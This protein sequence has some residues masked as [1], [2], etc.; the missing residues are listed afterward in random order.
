MLLIEH[1]KERQD[2]TEKI[3]TKNRREPPLFRRHRGWE[4]KNRGGLKKPQYIAVRP[5]AFREMYVVPGSN[6]GVE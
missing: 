2:P 6:R 4:L 3:L 5:T 1:T